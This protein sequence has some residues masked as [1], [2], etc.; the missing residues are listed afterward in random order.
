MDDNDVK[1]S[2]LRLYM[3]GTLVEIR[4]VDKTS[5]MGLIVGVQSYHILADVYHMMY[6][7]HTG[8]CVIERTTHPEWYLLCHQK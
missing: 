6:V 8:K 3:P 4:F 7:N 1:E 5:L 2:N